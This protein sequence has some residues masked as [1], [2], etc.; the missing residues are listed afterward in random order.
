[1]LSSEAVIGKRSGRPLIIVL[2]SVP[3]HSFPHTLNGIYPF[4]SVFYQK[5]DNSY[6]RPNY[7]ADQ[8]WSGSML[9]QL[10]CLTCLITSSISNF[11]EYMMKRPYVCAATDVPI[12]SSSRVSVNRGKQNSLSSITIP[13]FTM[14]QIIRKTPASQKGLF[15]FALMPMR[16]IPVRSP[17]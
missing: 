2:N 10:P 1:M 17:P 6:S 7:N 13:Q 8:L 12:I 9:F 16:W 5:L 11:P 3:W 4:N 14:H 15:T